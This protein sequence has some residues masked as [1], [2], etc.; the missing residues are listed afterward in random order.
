LYIT[1]VVF[2]SL[3]KSACEQGIVQKKFCLSKIP[4]LPDWTLSILSMPVRLVV[5]GRYGRI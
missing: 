3:I 1:G 4:T 2:G 5:C